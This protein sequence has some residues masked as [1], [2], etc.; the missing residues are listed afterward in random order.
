LAL[1]LEKVVPLVTADRQLFER[2]RARAE[3][4]PRVKW[5]GDLRPSGVTAGP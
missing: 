4:A 2:S 3:L 5:L 1:A